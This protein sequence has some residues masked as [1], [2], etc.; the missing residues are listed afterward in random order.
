MRA[1]ATDQLRPFR[2]RMPAD[3]YQ[4]AIDAAVDRLIREHEQLPTL[5]FE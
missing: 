3:T 4:R 1:E 2:E 5:T